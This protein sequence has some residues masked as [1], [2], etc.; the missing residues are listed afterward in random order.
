M[1]N[2]DVEFLSYKISELFPNECAGTYYVPPALQS[3][4]KTGKSVMSKGKLIDK[5]RNKCTFIR[6]SKS[7]NTP[8]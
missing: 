3:V 2:S 5:Y 4:S 6:G 1:E 7:S 8:V